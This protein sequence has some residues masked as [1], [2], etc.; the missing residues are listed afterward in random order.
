MC[1]D[2]RLKIKQQSPHRSYASMGVS[3]T[4]LERWKVAGK[5]ESC[6]VRQ[7]MRAK[8]SWANTCTHCSTE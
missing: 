4:Q 8:T 2:V 5:L 7:D 6:P 1:W 3:T